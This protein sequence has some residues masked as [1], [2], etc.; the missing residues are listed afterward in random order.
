MPVCPCSNK[1]AQCKNTV[2][3]KFETD[4]WPHFS[5]ENK[6]DFNDHC[7]MLTNYTSM[8]GHLVIALRMHPHH[9]GA[10]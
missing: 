8:Y 4:M 1:F 7:K 3:N 5:V 9:V 10:K 6:D 2:P